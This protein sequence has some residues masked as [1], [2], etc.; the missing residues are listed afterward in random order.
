MI[1]PNLRHIRTAIG[2]HLAEKILA[3]ILSKS[4]SKVHD[5]SHI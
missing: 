2:Q 4:I 5:I 3:P 1:L